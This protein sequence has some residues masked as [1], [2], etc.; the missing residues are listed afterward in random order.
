MY[1][2]TDNVLSKPVTLGGVLDGAGA[3]HTTQ[4]TAAHNDLSV[5]IN[6]VQT[7]C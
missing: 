6:A 2:H 7:S 3:G 1:V 5:K 4:L